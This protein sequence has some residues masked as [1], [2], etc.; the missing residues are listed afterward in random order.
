MKQMQSDKYTIAWFKI[1][2]YV[3]R[4]E[5]ERALGVYRLLSHS[6]NDDA[7]ARQLEGDI[8]LSCNE[9][10]RAIELYRLSVE[11]YLKTHRFL[12]AAAILE[13]LIELVP[14]DI[15]LRVNVI[16][17]YRELANFLKIDQHFHALILTTQIHLHYA[18]VKTCI[19]KI[20]DT[21][22]NTEH[23][24]KL[25]SFFATLNACD[26]DLYDY[27]RSYLKK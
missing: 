19:E 3:S 5:K 17:Y 4:G 25:Q 27:A 9:K 24:D 15:M 10:V 22:L 20:I 13:N 16:D 8:N 6:F 14:G 23:E 12:E 11:L 7:I 2:D 26:Q 1:A 21:F 18:L